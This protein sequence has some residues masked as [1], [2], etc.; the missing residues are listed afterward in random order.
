MLHY[1]PLRVFIHTIRAFELNLKTFIMLAIIYKYAFIEKFKV[2]MLKVQGHTWKMIF[3][4]SPS[5]AALM[6]DAFL[7]RW[8]AFLLK[9]A[10]C[11][12]GGMA[13]VIF[14]EASSGIYIWKFISMY[15]LEGWLHR[16]IVSDLDI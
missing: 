5:W 1:Y 8:G 13:T 16:T 15:F 11:L 6:T 3:F 14:S 2:I 12:S 7:L 10:S 4:S 9:S